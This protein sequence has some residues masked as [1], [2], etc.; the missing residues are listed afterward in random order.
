[1]TDVWTIRSLLA[2]MTQDFRAAGIATARLDAEVLIAHALGC[3]R[4]RLYMDL[5]R[6]LAGD[7]LAAVR[8]L[9]VR[10]RKRE[11]VAYIVGRREFFRRSFAVGPSV[12]IPRPETETLVERA[13]ELL[14]VDRTLRVLDLCTGSGAIAVTLLAERPSLRV[15]ATDLSPDALATARAN[16]EAHGVSDR[17]ELCCGDLFAALPTREPYDLIVANPPYVAQTDAPKLAPELGYEPGLALFAGSDGFA[18]LDR[19]CREVSGFLVPGAALLVEIGLGQAARVTSEL[20]AH[21]M[22]GAR[23][24]LDLGGVARVVEASRA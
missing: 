2:W 5:D 13:L 10:R 4:V 8:A 15:H 12:L 16:A 19:L 7:E 11:P 22:T 9:V 18:V 20:L 14:P 17:I 24:H 1:M 3:D 6:P 21:G 23:E